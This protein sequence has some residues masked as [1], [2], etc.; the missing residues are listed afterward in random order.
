MKK[1]RRFTKDSAFI[2]PSPFTSSLL[3]SAREEPLWGAE[4][5]IDLGPF[6]Q[7]AGA[8]PTELRHTL[9]IPL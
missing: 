1:V 9:Q 6:L 3:L 2:N 5:R 7:Q 4:P 8:L